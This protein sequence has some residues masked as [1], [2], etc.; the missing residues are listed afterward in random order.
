M[1]DL[2][3]SITGEKRLIAR[4]EGD[5]DEIIKVIK[6]IKGVDNVTADME[7]EKGAFDYEIEVKED[8]RKE[9]VKRVAAR[10]WNLLALRTDELTLEDIFLM[11]TM[12]NEKA[13]EKLD[14]FKQGAVSEDKKTELKAAANAALSSLK[15]IGKLTATDEHKAELKAAAN[16]A[17]SLLKNMKDPAENTE[18]AENNT[19]TENKK[20][21]E[22][23]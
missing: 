1:E 18:N 13:I 14:K 9:L 5:R 17:V 2:T 15:N 16:D 3:S 10:S 12:G 19:D 21:G 6:G 11:I 23:K 8:I 4:I 20:T 7:R 22:D